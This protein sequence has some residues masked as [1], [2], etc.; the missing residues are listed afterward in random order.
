MLVFKVRVKCGRS[1]ELA[2]AFRTIKFAIN[3]VNFYNGVFFFS[4]KLSSFKFKC[5]VL[6]FTDKDFYFIHMG[7]VIMIV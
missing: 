1:T 7:A 4:K 5:P 2:W 3:F 6:T